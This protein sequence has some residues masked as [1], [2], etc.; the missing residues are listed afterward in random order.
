MVGIEGGRGMI[1]VPIWLV[2]VAIAVFILFSLGVI[3][4]VSA[5]NEFEAW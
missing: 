3:I 2:A 5:M 4:V 1:L